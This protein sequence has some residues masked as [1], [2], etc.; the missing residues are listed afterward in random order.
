MIVFIV[1][2][3]LPLIIYKYSLS[4]LDEMPIKPVI[5]LIPTEVGELWSNKEICTEEQCASITP[6]W[7][8]RWVFVAL[9]NDN[10]TRI[11][12]KSLYENTPKMASHVAIY[13]MR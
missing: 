1:L 6:Y 2:M 13:H 5:M 7:I 9:V 11:D 12:L 8:Y 4:L 3:I 10:I